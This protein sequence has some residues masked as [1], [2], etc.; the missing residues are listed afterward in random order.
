MKE[1][2]RHLCRAPQILLGKGFWDQK[3]H[4]DEIDQTQQN[5]DQVWQEKGV[6]MEQLVNFFVLYPDAQV[7]I[8]SNRI[9]KESTNGGRQE[10]SPRPH[11]HGNR[12]SSGFQFF[13]SLGG[14]RDDG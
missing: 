10:K 7:R 9:G 8:L 4:R 6:G 12:H 1:I 14:F 5:R 13:V 11:A 3:H 2:C